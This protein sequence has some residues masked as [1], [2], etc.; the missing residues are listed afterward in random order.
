MEPQRRKQ[1]EPA[2]QGRPESIVTKKPLENQR[3]N[4]SD[5]H[6]RTK[7]NSREEK[8]EK[9][10]HKREREGE[11]E[12]EREREAKKEKRKKINDHFYWISSLYALRKLDVSIIAHL[13]NHN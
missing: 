4:K 2:K 10:D 5:K 3:K 13:G 1:A 11:R 6:K 7:K 12:R 8:H 9:R